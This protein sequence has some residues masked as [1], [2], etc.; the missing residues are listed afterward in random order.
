MN[1]SSL[2]NTLFSK[3]SGHLVNNNTA[4]G[5][6]SHEHVG[7]RVRQPQPHQAT[8]DQ[9]G[10]RQQ[11]GNSLSDADQRAKDQVSQHGCQL[12]DG[13]TEAEARAPA[14]KRRA[15]INTMYLYDLLLSANVNEHLTIMITL[16]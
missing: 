5:R 8:A 7:P 9:H 12:T 15:V 3:T 2:Y 14:N 10:R 16:L 11:D 4:F 6:R 1:Y 13:I